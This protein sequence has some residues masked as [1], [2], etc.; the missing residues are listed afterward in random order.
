MQIPDEV[1]KCVAFIYYDTHDGGQ[2]MAGTAFFVSLPFKD[3]DDLMHVLVVTAHHIIANIER[4]GA[5]DQVYLRL[6]TTSGDT[7]RAI[8]RTGDWKGHTTD[9]SVDVAVLSWSPPTDIVDF[10]AVPMAIAL[11]DEAIAKHGIGPGEDVFITGLFQ[12]HYGSG[13]NIPIIRVGNLALMQEEK[14]DDG[15]PYAP[16]DAYLIEARS[17]GG[18][19]GSPV[20]LHAGFTRWVKDD[21]QH[22]TSNAPFFLLGLIHGHWD[23]SD[24]DQRRVNMGIALVVPVEKILEILKQHE[25]VN[26]REQSEAEWAARNAATLDS[27]DASTLDSPER[28]KSLLSGVMKVTTGTSRGN[29]PLPSHDRKRR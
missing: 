22:S 5:T 17:T 7:I 13:R 24:D 12:R 26:W 20:F 28:T 27:V 4:Y 6:N 1:R 21:V 29:R 8:S 19:S 16:L 3:R 10:R 15:S 23:E 18:L 11:D 2:A 14:I 25:F 9:K